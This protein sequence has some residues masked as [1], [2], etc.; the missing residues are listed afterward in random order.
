M[1]G[2][3]QFIAVQN[4]RMNKAMLLVVGF[5]VLIFAVAALFQTK[6]RSD[7]ETPASR[8]STQPAAKSPSTGIR[9]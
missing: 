5:I 7:P 9:S 6:D 8:Q 4:N 2:G 1:D 3:I